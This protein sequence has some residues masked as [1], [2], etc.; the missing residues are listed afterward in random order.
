MNSYELKDSWGKSSSHHKLAEA[1]CI[2]NEDEFCINEVKAINDFS[3]ANAVHLE[4]MLGGV[5]HFVSST[6]DSTIKIKPLGYPLSFVNCSL[7][8]ANKFNEKDGWFLR[9]IV[10]LNNDNGDQLIVDSRLF[11]IGLVRVELIK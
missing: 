2:E 8:F 1:M 3:N 5:L 4:F 10:S 9:L 7:C 11:S 6:M